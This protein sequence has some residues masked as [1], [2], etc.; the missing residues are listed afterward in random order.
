MWWPF[1]GQG[2]QRQWSQPPAPRAAH[3]ISKHK[4]AQEGPLT[5]PLPVSDSI[6]TT[7]GNILWSQNNEDLIIEMNGLLIFYSQILIFKW[8]LN[9]QLSTLVPLPA[10]CCGFAKKGL[11]GK[12]AEQ[13]L[14]RH[15]KAPHS[16][17]KQPSY[18]LWGD[19]T[20]KYN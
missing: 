18:I 14:C 10:H 15:R 3:V 9:T 2:Y 17:N 16:N 12:N 11:L 20:R 6:I 13:L 4:A 7:H 8:K 1:R 19:L 5:M